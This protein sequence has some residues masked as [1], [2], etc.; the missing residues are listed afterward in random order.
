M[1]FHILVCMQPRNCSEVLCYI[2][3]TF[4]LWSCATILKFYLSYVPKFWINWHLFANIN[5]KCYSYNSRLHFCLEKVETESPLIMLV[6]WSCHYSLS[7]RLRKAGFCFLWVSTFL[8]WCWQNPSIVISFSIKVCQ[9]HFVPLICVFSL[10]FLIAS[11]W[12]SL[13]FWFS[14]GILVSI[15][16][17]WFLE[18]TLMYIHYSQ[19]LSPFFM[20]VPYL[21]PELWL[22]FMTLT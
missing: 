1:S 11:S 5:M 12:W 2:L 17:I 19:S 10:A 15:R 9:L 22:N 21:V 6:V 13:G 8:G 18:N 7:M 20:E 14:F 3:A 16:F 4:Y